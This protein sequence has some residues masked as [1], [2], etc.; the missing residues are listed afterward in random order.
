M[1]SACI[2]KLPCPDCGSSD[3][4]QAY[5]NVDDDLGMEWYTSFCHGACW[6]N[7]GDPYAGT[8]GPTVHIKSES[9]IRAEVEVIR[10]CQIFTPKKPYRGIPPQ[11]YRRW[12]C[13]TLLSEFDGKTP[14]AIGFPLS[15]YG[16]LTGWKCRP[17][18]KKDFYGVGKTAD[19]DP[20][21]FVRALKLRGDVMWWTEGEFDAI[22]LEYCMVLVGNKKG[23]PVVSL[24]HGGGSIRKNFERVAD[25]VNHVKWHVLVLDDDTVGHEAEETAKEMWPDK[26]IIIKKPKGCKDANDAVKAKLAVQMG[27]LALNFE[28]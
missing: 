27:N 3:S 11:F 2:E 12:G 14:Y 20:F 1:G 13:R 8:T 15:D 26:V 21:G 25:R 18:R 9:E 24:T 7:K 6:E 22:A 4:I 28:R 17:F 10:T 23:Y 16:E 19:S 5:L